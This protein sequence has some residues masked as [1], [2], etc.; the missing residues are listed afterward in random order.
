MFWFFSH[1]Y[2]MQLFRADAAM[3]KKILKFFWPWEHKKIDLKSSLLMAV[4]IFFPCSPNFSKQPRIEYPFY[5]FLYPMICG[6]ISGLE[7]LVVQD[8]EVS[9]MHKCFR[10]QFQSFGWP[11]IKV[12]CDNKAKQDWS[13]F[14]LKACWIKT[15]LKSIQI[16]QVQSI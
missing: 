4:W 5:R 8:L 13:Y 15:P 7:C 9:G 11:F 1:L 16:V 10:T 6:T 12:I 14:D 3:F 2:A